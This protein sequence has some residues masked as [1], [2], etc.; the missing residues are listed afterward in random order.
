MGPKPLTRTKRS[1][2]AVSAIISEAA[3][4]LATLGSDVQR[5]AQDIF[6]SHYPL[7]YNPRPRGVAQPG[8]VRAWGARGRRFESSRPDQ[9]LLTYKLVFIF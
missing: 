9:Y 1:Y 3:Y 6:Y 7:C 8:S 2:L 5:V 4:E